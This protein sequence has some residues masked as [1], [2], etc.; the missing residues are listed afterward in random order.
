MRKKEENKQEVNPEFIS[1]IQPQGGISFRDERFIKTGDG[2]E[3]CIYIWKYRKHVGSHWLSTIMNINNSVVILDISTENTDEARRNIN[4]SL[5][6]QESRLNTGKDGADIIDARHQ[7]KELTAMYEEISGMNEIVKLVACRVYIPGRTLPETDAQVKEVINYLEANG[8]RAAICLN[9]GKNDWQNML[10]PYIRQQQSLYKREGQ[11][12]LSGTL[13]IGN[14]FHFTN[15]NDENGSFYGE[16]TFMGGGSVIFDLFHRDNIRMS[17][18]SLVVGKM[19]S[20]KSTLLKKIIR[21]RAI[22]GDYIR[23]FDPTGEF[24]S[25]IRYL[26]GKIVP[27]DGSGGNLNALEIMK[28]DENENVSYNRHLSKVTTIFRYLNPECDKYTIITFEELLRE[29][30]IS[31]GMIAGGNA[32]EVRLTE[33]PAKMY[34]TFSDFLEFVEARRI[35]M[36]SAEDIPESSREKILRIEKIE[37]VIRNIVSNYGNIFDGHTSIDNLQKEQIVSFDIKNLLGNKPE[38]SDAQIFNALFLCW[39]NLVTSGQPM[40]KLYDEKRIEWEDIRRFLIILDESHRVISA[41]KT[42]G[43]EQLTVYERE[44]RKYFGG[45]LLASQSIRDFVPDNAS[46]EGVQSITTL[47]EL[48]TYKFLMNQ[49]SNCLDKLETVFKDQLTESEYERIPRLSKGETIL[50]IAGDKNVE[51]RIMISE[52]EDSLFTGGA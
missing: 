43:I 40:K 26:G 2:Y 14:P 30:Y 3:A 51:F 42:A 16:T 46:A 10:R 4:K 48:S 21:D 5:R 9:E 44:A 37:L 28:T 29:L 45:I 23:V 18:N 32:S 41:S 35:E 7:I 15:L 12:L 24:A 52:E 39:D 31:R 17:Y 34:P 1:R 27:L 13:S 19:G 50:S 6:E 49:D 25:L 22:R 20:G 38:I 11:P 33:L 47:F 36:E 8:Y